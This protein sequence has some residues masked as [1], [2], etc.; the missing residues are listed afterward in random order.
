VSRYWNVRVS[1]PCGWNVAMRFV[2]NGTEKM[3]SLKA[4]LLLKAVGAR[5]APPRTS[6][7]MF[8]R[9]HCQAAT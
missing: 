9:R 2:M 3:A 4:S 6:F 7:V 8:D 5:L 1:R